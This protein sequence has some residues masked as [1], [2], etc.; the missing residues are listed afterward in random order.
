MA[1][2]FTAKKYGHFLTDLHLWTVMGRGFSSRNESVY[3]LRLFFDDRRVWI[4]VVCEVSEVSEAHHQR[5]QRGFLEIGVS[6]GVGC[7]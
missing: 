5:L 4:P 3:F 7:S 6:R 2:G 1:M